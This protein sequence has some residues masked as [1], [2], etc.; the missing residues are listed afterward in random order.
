MKTLLGLPDEIIIEKI[1]SED[2]ELYAIIIK[3]YEHKLLRYV[4]NLI[5]DQHHAA[6]IVQ[7]TF[8]KAFI[9]LRGFNTKKKFSS[10]IYRIAHNEAINLIKKY[11]KE[12]LMPNDIDFKSQE[13]IEEDF[14]IQDLM[15]KIETCLNKMPLLYAEPLR[16]HFIDEKSYKEISDILKLPLGTVATRINRAKIIIKKL[17]HKK[18]KTSPTK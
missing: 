14:A 2:Q 4:S 13:N 16:L 10:W 11:H 12:N 17:C 18:Q 15:E 6:D 3:R 9:N 5:K 7:T 1:R 8:I